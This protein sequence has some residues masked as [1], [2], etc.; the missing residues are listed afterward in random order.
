MSVNPKQ[1]DLPPVPPAGAGGRITS[2]RGVARL[3]AIQALFQMDFR[4]AEPEPVVREF[5][6][7]RLAELAVASKAPAI[8]RDLFADIVRGVSARQEELDE[9][10]TSALV[11]GWRLERLDSVLRAILRAGTYELV[12]RLDVPAPV[13]INEYVNLAH[14]FFDGKEP[15]FA[16]AVLDTLVRRLRPDALELPK[17]EETTGSQ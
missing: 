3:G 17:G 11:A 14:A 16:N 1:N 13:V 2:S 7:Q 15:G 10:I 9:Q 5:L 8:D 12:A 6:D 4:N